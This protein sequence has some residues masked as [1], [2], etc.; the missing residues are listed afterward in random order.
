MPDTKE[1]SRK[2]EMITM[3]AVRCQ[4]DREKHLNPPFTTHL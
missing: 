3:R 4:K 2:R 1:H